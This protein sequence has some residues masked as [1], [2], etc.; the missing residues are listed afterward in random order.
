MSGQRFGRGQTP[1]GNPL[2]RSRGAGRGTNQAALVVDDGPTLQDYVQHKPECL[3][4]RTYRCCLANEF[5]SHGFGPC[6][7][8]SDADR[9]CT[10]G[11][12]QVMDAGGKA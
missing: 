1:T 4:V 12:D 2:R 9:R 5:H 3:A 10:C 6:V 11:L 7:A 8:V